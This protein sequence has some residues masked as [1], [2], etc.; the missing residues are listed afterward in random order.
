MAA[1]SV[2]LWKAP[3]GCFVKL[4]LGV[5]CMNVRTHGT[6]IH[7]CTKGSYLVLHTT[8]INR[9]FFLFTD[10]KIPSKLYVLTYMS[11]TQ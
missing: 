9:I 10:T 8:P 4:N 3:L 1:T 5:I 11:P 2:L 6:S 7:T